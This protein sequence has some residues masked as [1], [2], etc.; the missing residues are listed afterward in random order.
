MSYRVSLR[1]VVQRQ[2]DELDQHDY[3]IVAEAIS[4]LEQNPRPF[5]VRKLSGSGLWRIRV[6]RYRIV[7]AIDDKERLA[8]VVRVAKRAEDPYRRL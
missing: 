1:R 7:Y 2:L 3:E 6:R 4:A 8:I 5:G